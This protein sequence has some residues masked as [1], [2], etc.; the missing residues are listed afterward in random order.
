ME[1]A[2]QDYRIVEK[3]EGVG[4]F[5]ESYPRHGQLI[6][7]NKRFTASADTEFNLRHDWNSLLGAGKAGSPQMR[8]FS[9]DMFPTK[10][11]PAPTP[12]PTTPPTTPPTPTAAAAAPA[13]PA[14]PVPSGGCKG[15]P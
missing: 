14:A 3:S 2:G 12:P 10:V 9:H 8:H 5:F 11:T 15:E 6:S 7:L 13:A 1:A 4:S